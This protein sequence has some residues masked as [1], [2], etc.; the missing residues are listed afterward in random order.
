MGWG[1]GAKGGRTRYPKGRA[2]RACRLGG[3]LRHSSQRWLRGGEPT[4]GGT[5][6]HALGC[7][8][9]E[10]SVRR[11]RV[12]RTHVFLGELSESKGAE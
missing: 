9:D 5:A 3:S 7:W 12:E 2:G 6:E 10:V 1:V 8:E 11:G 4:R